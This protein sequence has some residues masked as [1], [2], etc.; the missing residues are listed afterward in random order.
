MTSKLMLLFTLLSPLTVMAIQPQF[1]DEENSYLKGRNEILM[2]IDPNWMPYEKIDGG[3]HIGMTYDYMKLFSEKIGLPI[4]LVPTTT[5]AQTLEYAKSRTCDIISLAMSTPE[6]QEY[7]NFTKP[8]ISIPLV[9]ATRIENLFIVNV[10]DAQSKKLGIVK[11]YAFVEILRAKYP[12]INLIEVSSI[13]EGLSKVSAGYLYGFIDSLS[14]IGHAIQRNYIGELKVAGKFDEK[15][16][17]G[18]SVRN[19][20][21]I[22]LSIFEKAIDSVDY[23]IKQKIMSKW[24]SVKYDK[25]INYQLLWQVIAGLSLLILIAIY[26]YF[27]R[28]ESIRLRFE[29]IHLVEQLRKQK[30]EAENANLAKSKFL[31][32]ASHDLR[33]PLYALSLFTSVLEELVKSPEILR[34]VAQI[35]TS[36][37]SMKSMFNALL[38][39]SQLDAGVMHPEKNNFLLP[40]LFKQL[41]NDFDPLAKNKNLSI[42]WPADVFAVHSDRELVEQILRNFISNAIRYTDKGSITIGCEVKNEPG[43]NQVIIHVTDTGIGIS[44][45]NQKAIFDEYKQINNSERD[46]TKGLGLGLGLA[47]VIRTADLLQHDITVESQLNQGSSF[48]IAIEQANIEACDVKQNIAS[49]DKPEKIT[50]TLIVVIDDDI[51]VLE[52]TQALLQSW[53]CTVIAAIDQ[54]QALSLIK[55]KNQIPDGIISDYRLPNNETGVMAIQSIYAAFHDKI[56]ALIVTGDIEID[57]LK[58]VDKSGLQMLP[59]PVSALKLRTFLRHVEKFKLANA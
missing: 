16:E 10:M 34:V 20:D 19:D 38:N 40:P 57:R 13:D 22:L 17:L 6:R 30:N 37:E 32:A 31:A 52:G 56:P 25:G 24:I 23:E 7:M 55:Q 9:I 21:L 41:A 4:T 43:H 8:Y 50:D 28:I 1:T 42:H 58:D 27:V 49:P 3:N 33:Q 39:I 48:S 35:K 54:Q 18:I 15:W 5:W 44:E 11:G 36:G 51:S 46:C 12:E 14:S 26:R 47:I 53:G 29:N 45:D 2:C 59:K